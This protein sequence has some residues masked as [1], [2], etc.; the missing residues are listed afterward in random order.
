MLRPWSHHKMNCFLCT[1]EVQ[2]ALEF[3]LKCSSCDEVLHYRCGMGYED[4]VKAFRVSPG[5]QQYKCPVCVIGSSYNFIHL[6]L[7]KHERLS[8]LDVQVQAEDDTTESEASHTPAVDGDGAVHASPATSVNGVDA[9]DLSHISHTSDSQRIPSGQE[10]RPR[11][12]TAGTDQSLQTV[13]GEAESRRVKRCKG[14]LYGLKHIPNT[15]D[16][17]I[18]LDS[19][20]RDIKVENIDGTGKKLCLRSIGGLCCAATTQALK[21]CKPRYPKIKALYLGLGTNDHLHARDHPGERVDYIKQLDSQIRKVFPNAA[22]NFILP[23]SAI[24]DLGVDYVK[25][26]AASIKSA[27]VRW[28]IHQS[29]TMKDKLVGPRFLHLKPEG[30]AAFIKWLSK[31]CAPAVPP[32]TV[33]PTLPPTPKG[34]RNR[35]RSDRSNRGSDRHT[36]DSQ[37]THD[38]PLLSRRDGAQAAGEPAPLNLDRLLSDRLYELL[39]GPQTITRPPNYRSRWG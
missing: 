9:G 10:Q 39:L 23:F 14:M 27:G 15:V 2:E 32:I 28:R 16:T 5:K 19:N 31:I 7:R 30:K 18:L 25:N 8:T 29:P 22:T 21:D 20:G 36:G 4:P 13:V 12:S 38:Y 6:A 35:V 33:A 37:Y 34:P 24:K 17:L 3:H 26:L 1:E 11:T